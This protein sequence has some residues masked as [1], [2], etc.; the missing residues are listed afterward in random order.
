LFG[1]I[2]RAQRTIDVIDPARRTLPRLLHFSS[3]RANQSIRPLI[4][5][6]QRWGWGFSSPPLRE[7]SNGSVLS[8]TPAN[9][10]KLNTP[11]QH[12][13]FA[14]RAGTVI[15]EIH[16]FSARRSLEPYFLTHGHRICSSAVMLTLNHVTF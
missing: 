7:T 11:R 9:Y 14:C 13:G 8:I 10:R 15:W 12:C 4:K 5:K 2:G 16:P 1:I 3:L 6:P